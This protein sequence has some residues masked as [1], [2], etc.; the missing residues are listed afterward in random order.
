MN[1]LQKKV[2]IL[3]TMTSAAFKDLPDESQKSYTNIHE[4]NH[5]LKQHILLN[6]RITFLRNYIFKILH[7][8]A[9]Y[10]T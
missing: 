4:I 10:S 9:W 1:T 3:Q 7:I 8:N 2:V 5:Q 6:I